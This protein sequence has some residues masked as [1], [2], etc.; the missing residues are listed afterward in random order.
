MYVPMVHVYT[1]PSSFV[2]GKGLVVCIF[3][4][5]LLQCEMRRVYCRLLDEDEDLEPLPT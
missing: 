2:V 4:T 3:I 1:R 5:S